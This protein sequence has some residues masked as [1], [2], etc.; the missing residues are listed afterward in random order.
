[1][2]DEYLDF[3]LNRKSDLQKLDNLIRASAPGLKRYSERQQV[4]LG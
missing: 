4:R 1:L 3:D 2:K